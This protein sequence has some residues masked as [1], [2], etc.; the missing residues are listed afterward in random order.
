[1]AN[2]Q[3]PYAKGFRNLNVPD[4]SLNGILESKAH[5]YK[6][7]DDQETLVR[8]ALE[9]PIDSPRLRELSKGKNKIVLITSDHTRPVPS[10]ITLP[11]LLAEIRAGNPDADITILIATGFH[12][13]TTREEM[14][15]KFGETVVNH[16]KIVNHDSRDNSS[17]V[18]LGILPSGGALWLNKLAIEADLLVSEG[19]IEPH[20]FAGFSG[21]RKSILPGIAGATTVL[22]NHCAKFIIHDRSRTGLLEGNPL[23]R[24]MLFAAE[25]ANLAFILNVIIDSEKRI[26]HAVAGNRK[27]AHEAGCDFVTELASVNAVYSDIAITSNGG[28]PLDQNIYQAVKGM[29]AAEACTNEN[30]VIIMTA[31]CNDGHGGEDFYQTFLNHASAEDVM[32]SIMQVEME[33]TIPDQWESQILA[34]ILLKNTVIL[35]T[36]QCDPQMIRDMKMLHAST[37]EDALEMA[38]GIKGRDAKITVIPDGVS[39]IVTKH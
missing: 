16:E 4:A 19:F 31:A 3:I 1:M 35:V 39:V 17:L 30:G 10:R 8:K 14:L 28:Y 36:D 25:T 13:L 11:I 12:R 34:R 37:F 7:S 32:N 21:G 18:H 22:A 5:H 9:N 29:T 26:I 15:D 23:H 38:Y 2:I 27:N 33:D 20:F 24:D 6:P